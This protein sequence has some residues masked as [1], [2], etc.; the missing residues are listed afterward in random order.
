MLKS[1]SDRDKVFRQS[2]VITTLCIVC[3]T[4]VSAASGYFIFRSMSAQAQTVYALIGEDAVMLEAVNVV[5]NRPVE[6]YSHVQQFHRHLFTLDPD[7]EVIDRNLDAAISMGDNSV[8]KLIDTYEEDNFYRDLIT[9]NISQ[10]V[11]VDSIYLDMNAKPYYFQYTGEITITR[12]TSIVTRSLVAE[13]YFRDVQRSRLNAHGFLIENYRILENKDL[14][15][16][17]RYQ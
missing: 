6:A 8:Q 2:Q 14:D 12:P 1:L 7:R 5:D 4:I 17:K 16:Q 9:G 10:S 3:L 15:I 11:V 13:G